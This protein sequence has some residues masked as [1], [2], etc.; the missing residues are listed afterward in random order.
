MDEEL[1]GRKDVTGA[2]AGEQDP[3]RNQN[4]RKR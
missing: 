3:E 2:Q 1:S 4:D